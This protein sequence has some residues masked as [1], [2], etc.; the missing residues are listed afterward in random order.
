L[1]LDLASDNVGVQECPRVPG[2]QLADLFPVQ[3]PFENGHLLPP[4]RPGLGIVFDESVA[5]K[6]PYKPGHS[7]ALYQLDGSMTNW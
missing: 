1:Q 7:P 6:Y 3:V 4:K 5:A 2:T